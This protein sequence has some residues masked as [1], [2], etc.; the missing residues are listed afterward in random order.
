MDDMTVKFVKRMTH[1]AEGARCIL[2]PP[3]GMPLT[4]SLVLS[5]PATNNAAEYEALITGLLITRGTRARK[6]IVKCDSQLLVNQLNGSYEAKEES[7][8][9]YPERAKDL[10]RKFD[11]VELL[12]IP[13]EA[14]HWANLLSRI[15]TSQSHSS[16]CF[17][18]K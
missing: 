13:R 10:A 1:T 17:I 18:E 4:Y 5:F 9:R 15:A 7:M 11:M 14:N 16:A 12:Q 8:K 2:I 6:V 3:N